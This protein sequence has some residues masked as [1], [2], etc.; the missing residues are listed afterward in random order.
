MKIWAH[1]LV[2]N[3]ENYIWY[4]INSVIDWVDKVLVWDTGS[5]DK[6][7]EIVKN[8]KKH[9]PEKISFSE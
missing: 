3:E 2:K 5:T 6:T 7:V 4:A 9:Y 8:I 1:T